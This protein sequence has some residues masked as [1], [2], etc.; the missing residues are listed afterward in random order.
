MD[1]II[2]LFESVFS[3]PIISFILGV[4][5][6]GFI[7]YL[8]QRR[9]EKVKLKTDLCIQTTDNLL[10]EIKQ[11]K[12]SSNK[13]SKLNILYFQWYNQ[14]VINTN[15]KIVSESLEYKQAQLKIDIIENDV[16]AFNDARNEYCKSLFSI[17]NYMESR[18]I[19]LNEFKGIKSELVTKGIELDELYI[20][21]LHLY[22]FEMLNSLALLE[23]LDNNSIDNLISLNNKFEKQKAI[24]YFIT[25][26]LSVGLQNI[27][28]SSL[29]KGNV[30][31]RVPKDP[32]FAIHKPGYIFEDGK[33]RDIK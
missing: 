25:E 8:F 16:N 9:S 7:S 19:I 2:K 22:H 1:R 29:F 32:E 24:I 10:L 15:N 18:Q 33:K 5:F 17:I 28:L 4:A 6:S 11:F 30:P 20:E 31:Y 21:I 26:D 23:P 12:D 3:N 13:W 27:F 14:F